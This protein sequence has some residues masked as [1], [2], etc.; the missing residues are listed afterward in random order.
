M[1]STKVFRLWV[2]LC[3]CFTFG[4]TINYKCNL[5]TEIEVV[6]IS[7][8]T[9]ITTNKYLV[10]NKELVL[11]SWFHLYMKQNRIHLPLPNLYWVCSVKITQVQSNLLSKSIDM[12]WK[13]IYKTSSSSLKSVTWFPMTSIARDGDHWGNIF[14]KSYT[15]VIKN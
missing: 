9:K 7:Y 1:T 3:S 5:G 4:L 6:L 10:N 13:E 12:T 8:F 14:L 11:N 15:L 2:C